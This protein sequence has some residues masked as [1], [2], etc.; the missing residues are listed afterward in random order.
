MV[1]KLKKFESHNCYYAL[2][3]LGVLK[4]HQQENGQ[5]MGCEGI[6]SWPLH[7]PQI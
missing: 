2:L 3:P 1:G 5:W 7:D 6:I 4:S